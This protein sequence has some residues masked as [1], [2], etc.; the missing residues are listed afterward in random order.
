MPSVRFVRRA[1]LHRNRSDKPQS[2]GGRLRDRLGRRPG[3]SPLRLE[4]SSFG[5]MSRAPALPDQ[6][7]SLGIRGYT[8]VYHRGIWGYIAYTKGI[9]GALHSS[10]SPCSTRISGPTTLYCHNAWIGPDGRLKARPPW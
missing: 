10:R 1:R 3:Q 5:S 8:R 9:P 7:I 2:A 4:R 6:G